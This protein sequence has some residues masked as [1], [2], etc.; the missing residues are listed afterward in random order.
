ME[1]YSNTARYLV[2]AM[3]GGAV[4]FFASVIFLI[5]YYG[6]TYSVPISDSLRFKNAFWDTVWVVVVIFLILFYRDI[7]NYM[8][9]HGATDDTT[10]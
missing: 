3:L 2:H 9:T 6:T 10:E 7:K 8:A 5:L 1:H 4:G